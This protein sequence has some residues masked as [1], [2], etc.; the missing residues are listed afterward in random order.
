MIPG[1]GNFRPFWGD[2]SL[3]GKY[4]LGSAF[5]QMLLAGGTLMNGKGGPVRPAGGLNGL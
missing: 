2:P 5:Y 1:Y 4:Q 3:Q